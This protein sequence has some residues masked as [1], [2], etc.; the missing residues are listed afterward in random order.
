MPPRSISPLQDGTKWSD[1]TELTAD[2]VV[3][4][5]ELGKEQRT[6]YSAIWEYM[7]SVTAPDPRSVQFKLKAKPYNP[8]SVRDTSPTRSS[9]PR[10]SGARSTR[11][12]WPPSPT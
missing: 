11:A 3:F 8:G 7:D 5:F 10:R 9:C 12:S 1:G 6:Y 2:D 4:T